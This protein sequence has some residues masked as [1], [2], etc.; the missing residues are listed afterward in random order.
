MTPACVIESPKNIIRV[1]FW[2]DI[3]NNESKIGRKMILFIAQ[4]FAV[5]GNLFY[6][7]STAITTIPLE[8]TV[9]LMPF[10]ER[11]ERAFRVA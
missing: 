8:G 2:C 11:T 6:F 4:N 9:T 5:Q 7:L 3:E 10:T 1:F